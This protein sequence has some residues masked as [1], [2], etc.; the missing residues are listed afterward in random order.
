M[1]PGKQGEFRAQ[2]IKGGY[3]LLDLSSQFSVQEWLIITG[4]PQRFPF[5]RPQEIFIVMEFIKATIISREAGLNR[6]LRLI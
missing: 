3:P 4:K 2:R 1:D 6:Q 5:G